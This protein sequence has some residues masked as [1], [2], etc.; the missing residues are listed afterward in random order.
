MTSEELDRL[1]DENP[2]LPPPRP[3]PISARLSALERLLPAV[4]AP[5]P[6]PDPEA[7]RRA[8]QQRAE[9]QRAAIWPRIKSPKL[10]AAVRLSDTRCA[11]LLGPT[12]VG[13]TSAARWAQA[14]Y[15]GLWVSSRELGACE[16][17]HPLG[18]GDP[19]LLREARKVGTLYL[20]DLGTEDA[21]DLG[22]I[23]G[24]I[25]ARYAQG[26]AIYATTGL[27]KAGLAEHLGAAYVRRLVEQHVTR[28][29]GTEM[30]VLFV[31][32]HGGKL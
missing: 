1:L 29:D 17:K 15:P 27:T 2:T 10:A 4:P 7:L 25:D 19:P 16:R 30:P 23:Q 13:K 22:V 32:C 6:A 20:D 9:H 3:K 24:L 12:G 21:R 28:R 8:R 11:L 31:D 5:T 18:D 26:R 14:R